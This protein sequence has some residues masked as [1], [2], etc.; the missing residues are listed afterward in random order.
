MGCCHPCA[1][2]GDS[3]PWETAVD[4]NKKRTAGDT[5]LED[6]QQTNVTVC[7]LQQASLFS[8]WWAAAEH[9]CSVGLAGRCVFGFA[10]AGEP[11]APNMADFGADVVLPLVKD[12]YRT[13]LKMLGPHAPLQSQAAL[14]TWNS[15]ALAQDAV[16]RYRRICHNMTKT[17]HVDE[18]FASCLNKSGYWL[19]VVGFW[20]AVLAQIWPGIAGKKDALSLQPEIGDDAVRL[21][22]D[23]FYISL[24]VWCWNSFCRYPQED[25]AEK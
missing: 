12:V 7:I 10:E 2:P 20:N 23:F 4:R 16:Y 6:P 13:V 25:L 5:V 22:M 17:L 8:N 11:G 14:L 21:A 9:K 24:S 1:I 15:T 19:S 18:T 3:V